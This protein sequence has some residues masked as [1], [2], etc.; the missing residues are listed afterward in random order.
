MRRRDSVATSCNVSSTS[1]TDDSWGFDE[2]KLEYPI[3]MKDNLALEL[4]L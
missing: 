2:Q 3:L 1:W 4:I